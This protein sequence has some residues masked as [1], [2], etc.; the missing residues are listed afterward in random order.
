MHRT[1]TT[2]N[3]HVCLHFHKQKDMHVILMNNMLAPACSTTLSMNSN[4]S[5][6]SFSSYK[7]RGLDLMAWRSRSLW[8]PT[9]LQLLTGQEQ[10]SPLENKGSGKSEGSKTAVYPDRVKVSLETS[11]WMLLKSSSGLGA[12]NAFGP[13]A[14]GK[15]RS[16]PS[17][18]LRRPPYLTVT[19]QGSGYAQE[20]PLPHREV[21]PILH[22]FRFKFQR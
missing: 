12:R 10:K 16:S 3:P 6:S 5:G 2:S 7:T 15:G 4:L 18:P 20:L 17:L 22:H 1:D 9:V 8:F 13:H 19:E 21:I 11:L 14:A